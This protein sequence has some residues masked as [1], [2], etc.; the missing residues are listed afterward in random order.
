MRVGNCSRMV[1]EGH[2]R[3]SGHVALDHGRQYTIRLG[4]HN[5]DR[6]ADVTVEVDGKEIGCFRVNAGETWTIETPPDDPGKGRFTFYAADSAAGAAVGAASIDR[7]SR[8]L[9]RATFRV[10][11]QRVKAVHDNAM[12]LCSAG[13]PTVETSYSPGENLTRGLSAGVTGLSGHSQQNFVTVTNLDYDPL[14]ET[15]ITLRLGVDALAPRPLKPASRS[16][17]TPQPVE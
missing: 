6:R 2:E 13:S 4:N 12:R 15:V 14:Q 7:E 16:N 3:E 17:P 10:E 1:P 11:R 8:G 5:Y 9:I